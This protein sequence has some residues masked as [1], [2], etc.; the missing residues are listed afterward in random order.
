MDNIQVVRT[1]D[2]KNDLHL[3]RNLIRLQ[4]RVE[5]IVSWS[6]EELAEQQSLDMFIFLLFCRTT[7]I[8]L[9]SGQLIH[10]IHKL[11]INN[12]PLSKYL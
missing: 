8:G 5:V 9:Y 10:F 3:Q 2:G 11:R 6:E 12:D 4:V 1:N 7:L